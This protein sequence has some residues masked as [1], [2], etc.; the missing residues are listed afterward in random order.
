M[1]E[2]RAWLDS[3]P[4]FLWMTMPLEFEKKVADFIGEHSLV[5]SNGRILLAVSGGADS[6]ALLYAIQALKTENILR[7]DIV[8]AHINH[9]LRGA[10]AD[11]DEDFVIAQARG[12]NLPIITKR[13]DVRGFAR[14]SKLSIETAARMLRIET[15]LN[16]AKADNCSSI[17]TAHHKNDNAETILHRLIRGTG[18]R[19]LAGIWPTR[20]FVDNIR[21]IRPLLSVTRDEIIGYLKKRNLKWRRDHTNADCTYTRNFVRH[22]LLPALQQDCSGSLVEQLSAL[23]ASAREFYT[24]VCDLAQKAWPQLTDCSANVLKLNLHMFLIH[25]VPVKV[26]LVWRSLTAVGCGQRDLTRQHFKR[27][28]RLAEQNVGGRKIDLPAGFVVRREYGNLIFVR[29]E[30]TSPNDELIEK[31]TCLQV[32]GRTKFGRF[33]IQAD[34]LEADESRIEKFKT[35][36]NNCIES[37][38]WD[39]IKLPLVVRSRKAGDRFWPLGLEA[40]KKIGK[41]LTSAKVAHH[42]RHKLLVIEDSEKIIWL[43]PVRIGERAKVTDETRKVLRLEIIE[44]NQ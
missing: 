23:A 19:G 12:L 42:V 14:K 28:L 43:W 39:K 2:Y 37:F 25:P 5:N 40:E 11:M 9:Q 27:I 18:F 32:P 15:L 35:E 22:R 20:L 3:R 8:C 31:S 16:I 34:I 7:A 29:P 4:V 24:K 17:A 36:K 13:L 1:L 26:E 30:K 41:F 33:L 21:F 6:T 10:D 38:D 44:E